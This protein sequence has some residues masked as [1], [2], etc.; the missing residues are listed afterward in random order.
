[1]MKD[2]QFREQYCDL[3]TFDLVSG[4][5]SHIALLAM[6]YMCVSRLVSGNPARGEM[7]HLRNLALIQEASSIISAFKRDRA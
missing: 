4:S 5:T 7:S 3:L 6:A 1:M 2:Y